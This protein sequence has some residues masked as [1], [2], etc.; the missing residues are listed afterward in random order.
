MDNQLAQNGWNIQQDVPEVRA[1]YGIGYDL[2][3]ATQPV[4]VRALVV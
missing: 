3:P 2:P 1:I 4:G